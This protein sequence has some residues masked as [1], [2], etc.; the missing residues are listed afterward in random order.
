MKWKK[1][2]AAPLK[3]VY[4][5]KANGKK[6]PLGI[7][8]M[9]DRAMQ[10]LQKMALEPIAET[11]SDQHS[12]GFRPKRQA[13]DAIEYSLTLLSK[14]K[15]AQWVLDADIKSC[16][17]QINHDWLLKNIP[18]NSRILKE[19]LKA[20]YIENGLKQATTMGTPQGSLCKA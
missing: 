15:S 12:Y 19:W 20:G 16:F 18:I 3:R 13:A 9:H 7:P 17:D 8:T 10:M 4:I 11:L 2:K 5:P 1:Y 6:R 14:K